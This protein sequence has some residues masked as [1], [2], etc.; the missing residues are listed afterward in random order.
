MFGT[1]RLL[2]ALLVLL[3]HFKATEVFSGLAV[4]AFFM[5][6]GFLITGIL[7]TRYGFARAGLIEFGVNR[8]IRLL[9]T[10]WVSV[11]AAAVLIVAFDG[12]ADARLVNSAMALPETPWEWVPSLFILGGTAFGLG[13]LENALSP[14]AWAV[15]VEILMYVCSGW[16]IARSKAASRITALACLAL[17][18]LLWLVSKWLGQ[19]GQAELAGSMTYSFLPAALL[20]YATGC[21]LWHLRDRFWPTARPAMPIAIATLGVVLCGTLVPRFSVTAAFVLSL[22]MFACL[23]LLLSRVPRQPRYGR[24]DTFFGFMSYPVYLMHWVGNYLVVAFAAMTGS[25]SLLFTGTGPDLL[26]TTAAG[27]SAV[28]VI[29]LGISALV[30]AWVE[31]PIER[32]RHRFARR[33][34]ASLAGGRS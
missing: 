29:T 22:P 32:Q 16:W 21:W 34:G 8:T 13:R 23:T 5:L 2:L 31:S 25:Q 12:V 14:S 19:Q 27:F 18:P 15:E 6:S 3:K 20:P 11:A 10:Y 4:W 26:Q 7:N 17:F 9:P 28:V 1:Y 24:F 30:A 33:I